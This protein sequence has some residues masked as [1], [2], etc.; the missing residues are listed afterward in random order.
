MILRNT[1]LKG[2]IAVQTGLGTLFAAHSILMRQKLIRA[3]GRFL[4][5]SVPND[6]LVCGRQQQCGC[7]SQCFCAHRR[8]SKQPLERSRRPARRAPLLPSREHA[9]LLEQYV[10]SAMAA[11][12]HVSA[13]ALPV[14]TA[15]FIWRKITTIC[16]APNFVPLPIASFLHTSFFQ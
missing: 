14:A 9:A 6:C 8:Q 11:S 13:V 2:N 1:L 16:A 5:Q 4:F 3:R 10:C 12:L 7:R 15:T